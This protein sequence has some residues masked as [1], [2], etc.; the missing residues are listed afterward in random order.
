[1]ARYKLTISC[2]FDE[3]YP[4]TAH[5][6][7]AR[8]LINNCCPYK[9]GLGES[10]SFCKMIECKGCWFKALSEGVRADAAEN[11]HVERLG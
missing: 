5:T 9:F 10:Y 11:V 7:A 1:M 4:L 6:D 8:S 3:S 2:E